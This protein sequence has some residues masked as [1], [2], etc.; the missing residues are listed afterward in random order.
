VTG[1]FVRTTG[2]PYIFRQY[3]R[4]AW[5]RE[6]RQLGPNDGLLLMTGW[7]DAFYRADGDGGAYAQ[8][9]VDGTRRPGPG[10]TRGRCRCSWS[11]GSDCSGRT[12]PA[13]ARSRGVAEVHRIGLNA[14]VVFVENLIE[15]HRL[16]LVGS[17]APGRAIAL[18]P[19]G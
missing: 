11:V 6:H 17:G 7:T 4:N 8:D 9:V 14:G 13:R 10:S 5:E 15:L 16:P 18:I 3:R 19:N 12:L 2:C 1:R